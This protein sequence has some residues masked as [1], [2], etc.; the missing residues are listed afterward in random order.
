MSEIKTPYEAGY[1]SVVNEPNTDNCNF[2]W[3]TTLESTKEW[4]AGRDEAKADLLAQPHNKEKG[5]SDGS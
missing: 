4:E 2:K 1:D 3:F 5:S